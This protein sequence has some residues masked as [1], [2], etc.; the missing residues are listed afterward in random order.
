MMKAA[1]WD[2]DAAANSIESNVVY[3]KRAHKQYAF[4]SHISQRMFIGFHHEN[5][6]IKADGGAVSKESFSH[7]FLA[8]REM[9]PLDMLCQNPNSVFGKFCTS[10]YLVVVHPKLEASFFG[11]LDQRN[12]KKKGRASK[13]A[14]LPGLL[15]TGQVDLAFSQAC[16]FL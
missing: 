8:T 9:D 1:G 3:A 13:N 16:L 7:Q 12:Y 15:E 5:F 4:E 6:S 10:K 11:N 14:L 2:L